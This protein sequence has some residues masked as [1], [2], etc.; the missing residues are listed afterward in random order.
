MVVSE[1]R[2]S[3]CI[4][5]MALNNRVPA[6][7]RHYAES[8]SSRLRVLTIATCL[9]AAVSGGFGVFQLVL[10]GP[11]WRFGFVNLGSAALFLLVPLLYRFGEL[12]APLAFFLFAY[13]SV[14]TMCFVVGTGSGLQ[15]YFIVAASLAVLV[16]GIER[17]VLAGTLTALAVA[18]AI[19]LEVLV[20]NDR[21]LGPPWALTAGFVLSAVSAGVMVFATVWL[22][23]REMA[24]AEEAMEAEYQRSEQLLANILPATIAQRL[25]E[26]SRTIIA[27][28]YDDA[29]ILFADIAG[30]TERASDITPT[31]LVRF[32]D[33]LYTD[34]DALVDRHGLEKVKTSGDSYMVV[35]GVPKPRSDHIEALACLALDLAEAVADLKDPRG[36]A[37]P[38]RIGLAAGPVVAGV[39][40]ARKFF[41]DVWGDAV[42]VAS[43]METTDVAGRIQ[44]PHNVYERIS[45]N[46][47]LEERGDV[48][49]KGKGLMHT[50]YLVGRRDDEAVRTRLED[51]GPMRTTSVVPP[52]G[53]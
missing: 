4:P 31:E 2:R 41:Y 19:V 16:L 45:H 36:R 33:R 47:V 15:F 27:D 28:K 11:M 46:F 10:G 34:L 9:A 40:G 5:E 21:G 50:W 44:V 35:A 38:L 24:R 18:A 14:S 26:P 3:V 29:S 6:R 8:V 17:I 53:V 43:R 1:F 23:L 49:V 12:I 39:V 30:Y 13:V 37:V 20:P 48:D 32:L 52:A 42:N 25:K 7:T 22:S 51:A